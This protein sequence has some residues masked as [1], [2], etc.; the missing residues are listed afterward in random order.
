[1]P[2]L[3]EVDGLRASYGKVPVLHDVS[4]RVEALETVCILGANGAGKTTLVHAIAGILKPLRGRIRFRGEEVGGLVPERLATR[5]LSLV[6][7]GRSVF[8]HMTVQ[9]NLEMG[10]FLVREASVVRQR[11]DAVYEMFPALTARRR[12]LA[13]SMSGGEQKMLE[14]GR[15]LMMPLSLLMLDEPSLGLAPLIVDG[16]F[17][18]LGLL[19]RTGITVLLVEQNATGALAIASRGYV[20]ELGRVRAEGTSGALAR[21]P[22]IREAYL[23]RGRGPGEDR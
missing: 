19:N 16:I 2:A 15:S 22:E 9:E 1:M 18:R 3:L 11:L 13:G 14:I 5:G 6:R 8:P 12:Q 7:Q 20:L 17:E 21:N 23:G 10:A 4:L